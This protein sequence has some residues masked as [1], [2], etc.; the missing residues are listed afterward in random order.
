MPKIFAAFSMLLF[1]L[2]LHSISYNL[3]PQSLATTD[4]QLATVSATARV[5]ETPPSSD[6]DLGPTPPI[7]ISPV[8]GTVTGDNRPEFTWKRSTDPNGNTVIYTLYLNGVATYLGIS[9][10]GNSAGDGYTARIDSDYIHLLTNSSLSDGSYDWYV[11]AHDPS[12][13]Q[14]SSATWN[15]TIDTVAPVITLTDVDIYHE[16]TYNS[17]APEQFE[18]LNFDINGPKD[19]YFTIQ[20]ES[21]STLTIKFYDEGDNLVAQSSWP[22]DG[23]GIAH[24]YQSLDIGI[25]RVSISAFDQGS[26]T[27]ALPDFTLTIKES[28]IIIPVPQLPGVTTPTTIVI[29]YTIPTL[30]ATVSQITSRLSPSTTLLLMLAVA[31]GILIFILW[32]RKYNIILLDYTGNPLTNTIVYHSIPTRKSMINQILVSNHDPIYYELADTSHGRLYIRHLSRYSTLTVRTPVATHI[33]SM[34]QKRS[35]YTIVL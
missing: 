2:Y 28:R 10:I 13:N 8:D 11:T 4:P 5:P 30:P 19:V 16:L 21:W 27:T 6:D 1:T 14:S 31:I 20:S 18:G 7:L 25:F 17:N 29:P 12:L 15:L 9:D 26:N 23:T 34:S 22:V 24:P 32:K 35:L 33:L 3:F